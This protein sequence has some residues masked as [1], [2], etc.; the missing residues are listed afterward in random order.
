MKAIFKYI[1]TL[2]VAAN[3][4]SCETLEDFLTVA[5]SNELAA[6][7]FWTS[8]S[9]ALMGLASVYSMLQ[10][11]SVMGANE[12]VV[13]SCRTDMSAASMWEN[14]PLSLQNFTYNDS[15]DYLTNKWNNLYTGVYRANQVLFYVPDIDM[16]E[17]E[18]EIILAE[19]HFLRGLF[20]F[21]LMNT[22]NEGS[23]IV[24]TTPPQ[25]LEE[26]NRPLSPKE[27][28]YALIEADLTYAATSA[29]L[30][31]AWDTSNLGRATLGA[32]K[33]I[34]GQFYLYEYEYEKAKEQFEWFIERSDLYSLVE[35]IGWNFD[36]EHEWNSESIFEVNF[37]DVVKEGMSAYNHDSATAAEATTRG[38]V[39]GGGEAGGYSVYMPTCWSRSIFMAD[40]VDLNNP[41]NEEGRVWSK[42][43]EASIYFMDCGYPFYDGA[44]EVTDWNFGYQP[45]G[46]YV[47]KFQNWDTGEKEDSVYTRSGI[48]ERVL[49]LADVFL[50][51]AECA[52]QIDGDSGAETA[53]TYINKVR[54]RSGVVLK[55][56]SQLSTK[57]QVMDHLMYVERPLELAWEGHSIRWNDLRRWHIIK[58]WYAERAA[59]TWTTDDFENMNTDYTTYN[60]MEL[61]A[62]NFTEENYYLMIPSSETTTNPYVNTSST[63]DEE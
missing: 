45:V 29:H 32:A 31:E 3:V 49:R 2:C 11:N 63:T 12:A 18:K 54:E 1:C 59:Y 19:A 35:E 52:V 33:G 36:I 56:A 15:N 38:M 41:I 9:D 20:Y 51:Y 47:K 6:D 30:P 57:E 17:A 8:D 48:N 58:E 44:V 21:W 26:Y 50:M 40:E 34:L 55:T 60:E 4:V 7:T 14:T 25:S 27:D 10:Y 43:C 5:N 23:V 46:A 28:V 22:F 53:R 37:S 61:S 16:D 42:R 39:G 24:A 62:A 13:A